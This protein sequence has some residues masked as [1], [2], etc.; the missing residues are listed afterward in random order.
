MLRNN[1]RNFV[2][3]SHIDHGKST[4][5]DRFLELTSTVAKEKMRSQFLDM[6][7]L[8]RER[9][10]TI[11][12]AP[13]RM[14]WKDF[15]LNLIDTP[16]HADFQYEVSRALKAVEG[17][18]LLVDATQGVQA[19]TLM[20]LSLAQKENLKIIPVI[21]K[22]DL[23][24]ADVEKTEKDFESLGFK[25]EEILKIS[26]KTGQGVEKLLQE[27]I[28]RIPPPKQGKENPLSALIFD[29]KY[30]PYKGAV[31][32]VRIFDGKVKKGDKIRFMQGKIETLALEVGY[33]SPEFSLSEALKAGE[34]GY[35]KTGLKE[36]SQIKIGD[37]ITGLS[38]KQIIRLSDFSFPQPSVFAS[39]YPLDGGDF[40]K[41][42]YAIEKLKLNDAS[43]SYTQESSKILGAGLRCGFLGLFHLEITKE[44]LERHF[45]LD[46]IVTRPHVEIRQENG[47]YHEP[48]VR[49]EIVTPTQFLG[50]IM[51]LA[52]NYRGKYLETKHLSDRVILVYEIPLTEIIADFYDN[53]KNVS[54]GFA[55]MHYEM[56][57]FRQANLVKLDVLIA[58]EKIE[59]LSQIVAKEKADI[60]GRNL[61]KRLKE[62][63]PRQQFEVSLQAVIGGKIIA[64]E[65]ISP[66]R[67]DVTAKLYGG[68]ITRKTKLLDKQAAGKKRLKQMGKVQVP[69]DIFLKLL[70]K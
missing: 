36:I 22:I 3:I 55:S 20:N 53:L 17:A 61:V 30:D 50:K 26:A 29:A 41:L 6:M 54:S 67:K 21:N 47:V 13:A 52:Q 69:S 4:L 16:G 37:T 57:G 34:I 40:S 56:L 7:D 8:E 9:G 60:I 51:Q 64:R 42:F 2:I 43:L 33:F 11:K 68:D 62:I 23:P 24:V 49:L 10:V 27:L 18:V 39:I 44:R 48:Y 31:V 63:I 45:N 58:G 38:D 5:A 46:I 14:I 65:D 59:P 1:I 70:K 19:Q 15:I 32:Y 12:M 35:I 28:T 25:K 66:L